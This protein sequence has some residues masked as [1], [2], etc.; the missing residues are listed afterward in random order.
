MESATGQLEN[1][2]KGRDSSPFPDIRDRHG[3]PRRPGVKV[4]QKILEELTDPNKWENLK[5]AFI[6]TRTS[7]YNLGW[8]KKLQSESGLTSYNQTLTFLVESMIRTK[9]LALPISVESLLA[10]D[11][12]ALLTSGS[13]TG[14]TLWTRTKLLPILPNLHS[15]TAI[16]DTAGEYSSI[17]KL[18]L[19]DLFTLKWDKVPDSTMLRFVPNSSTLLADAELSMFFDRLNVVKQQGFTPSRVPS[20]HLSRWILICEEGHRLLRNSSFMD[21]LSESR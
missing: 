20:G 18:A 16:I 11:R 5:Q 12:P 8:L 14:K 10:D 1:T 13:G 2:S 4:S 7:A 19:P 15:P 3:F 21:F 6:N 9:Q 17:R